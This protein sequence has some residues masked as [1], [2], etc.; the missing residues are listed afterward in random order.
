MKKTWRG[1]VLAMLLVLALTVGLVPAALAADSSTPVTFK[2]VSSDTLGTPV[3]P[4]LAVGEVSPLTP[5]A[6]TTSG[7]KNCPSRSFRDLDTTKWYHE[8]IDTMLNEGLMNG[9]GNGLFEPNATLTRAMLVTILWRSEGKPTAADPTPFTDVPAGAYYA[10]AVRW[11]AANG[12]VKGVSST[13]FGPSRNITRQELV[14]ILWR[15][16]AKKG[17]NTSNAGLVAPEF[18]DR[19]QIAAW[20]A[21]AMSWGSTRGILNGKGANRVDPNG[22][23]TARRQRP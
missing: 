2:Q 15:L 10:E 23:A 3:R 16:A 21:E 5:S 20:A 8:A 9:T 6:P 4:D 13:E 19:S 14:T 18:A 22:T 17:L 1:R 12:I 7:E 11:A